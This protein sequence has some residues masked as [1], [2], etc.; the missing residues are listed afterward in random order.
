[1]AVTCLVVMGV[2]GAGKSTIA[3]VVADR[4]DWPMAEGDD[5]HPEK[6]V[7]KMR[8]GVP[9]TDADRGPW[10]RTLREWIVAR[11]EAGESSVMTCSAL[12]ESYR[13]ILRGSGEGPVKVRVR[14]LHLRGSHEEIGERMVT[15][16]GHF[17]P[18]TLL[19][20]QLADLEPLTREEDGVTV[21]V[22]AEPEEVTD[23]AM[24]RLGLEAGD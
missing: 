22:D 3:R 6:N 12:K 9:L 5:F 23:T 24:E 10:L 21:D 16:T 13:D 11:A 7:A 17:M 14:F 2:S 20:S 19:E 8:A 4:L 15:R 18:T 1:M